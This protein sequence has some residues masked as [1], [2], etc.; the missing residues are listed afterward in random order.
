MSLTAY[1]LS[2]AASGRP[3]LTPRA[4]SPKDLP[5]R[6]TVNDYFRRWDDDGT[7]DR[8]HQA[9]Y[10]KCRELVPR[11]SDFDSLAVSG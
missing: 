2:K 3:S 10:V 5:P 9:L 8:I 1:I 4:R 7:L 6:S 11:H